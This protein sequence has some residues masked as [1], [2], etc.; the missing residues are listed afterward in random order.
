MVYCVSLH[1]FCAHRSLYVSHVFDFLCIEN[2]DCVSEGVESSRM[3][4]VG[5]RMENSPL[6]II[7]STDL[8]GF[9]LDSFSLR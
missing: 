4:I 3:V 7:F 5:L 9:A 1:R 6:E 2:L 8:E